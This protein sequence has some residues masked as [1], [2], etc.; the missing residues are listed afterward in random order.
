MNKELEKYLVDRY[1]KILSISDANREHCYGMFGFECGDGW[2]LHLN[3]MFTAIQSMI[4]FSESSYEN[5]QHRYNKLSWYNKL[6]SIHK[7]SR[8]HYLRDYEPPIP[9]VIAVQIKE[10]FGTL[11]FYYTGGDERI[12]PI[13]DFYESYTAYICE[14]CGSIDNIGSTGGW[15]RNV[16]EKHANGSKRIIHNSDATELFNKIVHNK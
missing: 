14:D 7:R 5:S 8:Y 12:T 1:P 15:I 11:R 3:R 4:D 9:Q 10:K 16:C 2:F 13:V 6:C